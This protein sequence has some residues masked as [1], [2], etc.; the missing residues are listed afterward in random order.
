MHLTTFLIL[1]VDTA[2]FSLS[3]VLFVAAATIE[4]KFFQ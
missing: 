4:V 2:F 1:N 3:G